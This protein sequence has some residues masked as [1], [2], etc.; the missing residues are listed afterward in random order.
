MEAPGFLLL[1]YIMFTLP[2]ELNISELP[3]ENWT[4]VAMFVS[5]EFELL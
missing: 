3:K 2:K 1:L 4:M 5:T